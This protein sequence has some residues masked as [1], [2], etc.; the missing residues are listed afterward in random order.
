MKH[1]RHDISNISNKDSVGRQYYTVTGEYPNEDVIETINSEEDGDEMLLDKAIQDHGG[2]Y[3]T[4][5]RTSTVATPFNFDKSL[6]GLKELSFKSK[7]N[8]WVYFSVKGMFLHSE[9][10]DLWLCKT[11]T[12]I[13]A[14]ATTVRAKKVQ[15]LVALHI[16]GLTPDM[17]KMEPTTDVAN[18]G[19]LADVSK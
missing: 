9:S 19:P 4:W 2:G 12:F 5:R 15:I 16:V 1:I 14:A 10:L 3:D 6:R 8:V 11:A 13:L 7:P 18:V 17:T